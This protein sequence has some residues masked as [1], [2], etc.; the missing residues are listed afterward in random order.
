M[1][2]TCPVFVVFSIVVLKNY[3]SFLMDLLF[4]AQNAFRPS[5]CSEALFLARVS[6]VTMPK[7]PSW[8]RTHLSEMI[9]GSKLYSIRAV[10]D[11]SRWCRL[12]MALTAGWL[13]AVK[14]IFFFQ[15]K[16]ITVVLEEYFDS[17]PGTISYLRST[18]VKA[19]CTL[20][21]QNVSNV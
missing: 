16:S 9:Y 15:V 5:Y 11:L 14:F 7:I 19:R 12:R 2:S 17:F 3:I 10:P 8:P 1:S 6:P 20:S 18:Y 21:S 4:M 13:R